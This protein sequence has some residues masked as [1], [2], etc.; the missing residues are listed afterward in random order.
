MKTKIEVGLS[1]IVSLIA[2]SFFAQTIASQGLSFSPEEM[3]VP[4]IVLAFISACSV[5]I[6]RLAI[7]DPWLNRV[8]TTLSLL[9]FSYALSLAIQDP[10][11]GKILTTLLMG[12]IT[13]LACP[14]SLSEAH[15][16]PWSNRGVARVQVIS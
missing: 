16:K 1:L 14:P 5:N 9:T 7:G 11:P 13:L 8:S 6:V 12:V 3:A 10:R 2:I 15:G 4:G